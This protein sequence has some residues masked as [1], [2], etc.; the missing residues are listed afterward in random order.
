MRKILETVFY[1]VA[2]TMLIVAGINNIYLSIIGQSI[3]TIFQKELIETSSNDISSNET[4][5][6][7]TIYQMEQEDG[8]NNIEHEHSWKDTNDYVWHDNGDGTGRLEV[9]SV[10]KCKCG[11]VKR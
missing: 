2:S 11:L 5:L 3:F 4:E 7:N 6:Q 1:Y 9:V 10:M 8:D